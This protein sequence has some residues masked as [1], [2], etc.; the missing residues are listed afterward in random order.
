MLIFNSAEHLAPGDGPRGPD[1]GP[2][3]TTYLPQQCRIPPYLSWPK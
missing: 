1:P 2:D 3:H